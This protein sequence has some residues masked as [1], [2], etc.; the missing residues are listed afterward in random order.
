MSKKMSNIGIKISA[1]IIAIILWSF[2]MEDVNPERD[3]LYRDIPVTFTNASALERQ[4]LVILDPQEVT[5]NVRVA[6]RKSDIENFNENNISAQVDLSGYSEG[7]VKISVKVGI[8]G[9]ASSVRIVDHEPREILFNFDRIIKREYPVSIVTTGELGENYLLGDVDT[10]A[11]NILV[12]G[13]RTWINQIHEMV[14]YVDLEE[15]TSTTTSNFVVSAVD[16]NGN[17][18]RG[19][20][21][22]PSVVNLEIPIFRTQTVPIEL[23]TTGELPENFS[24]NNLEIDP[25]EVMVKGDHNVLT[26]SKIDTETIDVDSFLENDSQEVEL[27]LP[28]GVELVDPD[29]VITISYDIEE[30]TS[31]TFDF[32][33]EEIISNLPE[34][35]TVDEESLE[36][37]I[38][39]NL[40][41]DVSIVNDIEKEDIGITVDLEDLASGTH[42]IEVRVEDIEGV[43]IEVEPS[44]VEIILLED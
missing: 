17:E 39:V 44:N 24:V 25:A 23:V 1:V 13:P 16:E 4:E 29:E 7:Q 41:G 11:Y 21:K 9:Q 31:E 43:S 8:T 18:V 19:V 33:L 28:E 6:G 14:A 27:I 30:E 15:R 37:T 40:T 2:V 5:V 35:L 20:E 42:E 26:L 12:E 10:S 34:T 32:E 3:R 38:N 22:E 36:Q